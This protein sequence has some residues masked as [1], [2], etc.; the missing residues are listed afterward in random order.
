MFHFCFSFQQFQTPNEKRILAVRELK[1][2]IKIRMKKTIRDII[3]LIK[4]Q[5]F[6]F[7]IKYFL[8]R[9]DVNLA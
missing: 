6:P 9:E 2:N 1:I 3:R 5:L 7:N 4:V 8:Y